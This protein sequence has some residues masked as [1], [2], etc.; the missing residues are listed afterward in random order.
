MTGILT[1]RQKNYHKE[2]AGITLNDTCTIRQATGADRDEYGQPVYTFEEYEEI[3]CGI[4]YQSSAG[5]AA[6]KR[7]VDQAVVLYADAILR[8]LPDQPVSVDD[9]V[10]CRGKRYT[11]DGVY[12]GETIRFVAL[13]SIETSEDV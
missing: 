13:K 1:D 7:E 6:F 9:T 2:Q 12:D 11:I 10:T 4:M 5:F 8:L 3:P